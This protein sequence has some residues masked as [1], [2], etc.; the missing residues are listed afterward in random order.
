M[1]C[2]V[3]SIDVHSAAGVRRAQVVLTTVDPKQGALSSYD[4]YEY[5]VHSH[6]YNTDEIPA[7]RFSYAQSPIQVNPPPTF[8][9]CFLSS[10]LPHLCA[11]LKP[12][13]RSN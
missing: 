13:S 6:N 9:L 11:V 2:L 5:V 7:A 4:A 1:H 8:V 12:N 3:M 10:C